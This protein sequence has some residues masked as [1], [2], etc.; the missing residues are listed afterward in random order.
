MLRV[1]RVTR[2]P[3]P[4]PLRIPIDINLTQLTVLLAALLGL[5]LVL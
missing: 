3:R 2:R 1:R 4:A 5:L